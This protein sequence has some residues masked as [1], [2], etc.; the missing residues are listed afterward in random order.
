MRFKEKNLLRQ[1]EALPGTGGGKEVE[2]TFDQLA[3]H[4]EQLNREVGGI[5][6][7]IEWIKFI[8]GG[9]TALMIAVLGLSWR[10]KFWAKKTNNRR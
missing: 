9:Q 2:M 5:Q 6:V 7:A 1:A 3:K 10:A 8:L 4:V